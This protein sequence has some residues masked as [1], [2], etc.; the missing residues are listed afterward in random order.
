[1]SPLLWVEPMHKIFIA[2]MCKLLGLDM[3]TIGFFRHIESVDDRGR[4]HQGFLSLLPESLDL[5]YLVLNLFIDLD[6][7]VHESLAQL[8]LVL[9]LEGMSLL[10]VTRQNLALAWRSDPDLER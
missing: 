9:V 1:M 5:L 2:E 6:G 8:A 4:T 10:E 7:L 3:L